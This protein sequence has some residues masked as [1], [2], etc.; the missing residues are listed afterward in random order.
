MMAEN[1]W[2]PPRNNP[3]NNGLGSGGGSGLGSYPSLEVAA[4]YAA[5]N[6]SSGNYGYPAV[7]AALMANAPEAQFKQAII[8]SSWAGGHYQGT[9]YGAGCA[10]GAPTSGMTAADWQ[11]LNA[12]GQAGG[13]A[14]L[15]AA[16]ANAPAST[17]G[18]GTGATTA[19]SAPAAPAT[20]GDTSAQGSAI[21]LIDSTLQQYG[22]GSLAG[23]AWS[24]LTAGK[25]S[26]Q[27]MLDLQNQPAYQ[28][29]VFGTVNSA[30]VA[31]GLKP[32]TPS[33]IL[34]YQDQAYQFAQAAGLPQ[35]FIDQKTITNLLGH[36]VSA[37]ELNQRITSGYQ[38]AMNAPGR[39]EEPAQP[40][41]RRRHRP[42]RGLLPGPHQSRGPAQEPACCRRGRDPGGPERAS[43]R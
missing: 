15:T 30:R 5:Q 37:A 7:K 1:P 3:L 43:G 2:P 34:T 19:G 4:Q 23:W 17:Y 28:Q 31:A 14:Y 35:G 18:A 11:A 42:P 16:A 39:D 22:L 24:E 40:V 8:N 38:A 27:I 13:T 36:D 26:D 20:P 25:N 9:S 12:A 32:M 10:Q 29:S 33:D 21:S 6:L 41:L